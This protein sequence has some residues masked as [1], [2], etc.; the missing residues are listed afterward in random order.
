MGLRVGFTYD[1][2]SKR[3]VKEGEPVDINAEFDSEETVNNIALALESG[4]HKVVRI[5]GVK[6]LLSIGDNI[7]GR[8]DIV[9]N[10]CEGYLGRNREAQVPV[11]LETLN[12]P[13]VGS[14]G[15]TLSL[16]LDKVMTKKVLIS[17]KIPTPK[18]FVVNAGNK[19][20][21]LDHL[22]FPLIAK[23]RYEGTS[24][25]LT[26]KSRV[27][28]PKELKAQIGQLI[29]NYKQS[30]LVEE[31]IRGSEFTVPIIG[32]DSPEVFPPAQV[33]IDNNVHLGDQFYTFD[34]IASDRLGYIY[35]A[36]INKALEKK[37]CDLAL[38]TYRAVDCRDFGRVDFR[39]DDKGNLYVLEINPLPS[40]AVKDI[41]KLVAD[42]KGVHFHKIINRILDAGIKRYKLN[43]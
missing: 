35:P 30:V 17:E 25:G 18:Y 16:T 9:F 13:F 23:L 26:E 11:I 42:Y 12:V 36:K 15:L 20:Y 43:K 10:I 33:H 38:S 1:L 8:V 27:D 31:F 14:D 28:N 39:V 24:K 34:F 2:K 6:N 7:R 19:T 5:G 4:G 41:F 40:L 21:N 37:I 32:N 3:P 29:S 22:R